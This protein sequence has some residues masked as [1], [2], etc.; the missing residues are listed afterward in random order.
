MPETDTIIPELTESLLMSDQGFGL[1][2]LEFLEGE[3]A[4]RAHHP[5]R[6]ALYPRLEDAFAGLFSAYPK[7]NDATF[8][9][10]FT[11]TQD[12]LQ[13]L[14]G[15]IDDQRLNLTLAYVEELYANF[16][17]PA[18]AHHILRD[19]YLGRG[20][21]AQSNLFAD[22]FASEAL[23]QLTG[24]NVDKDA[25]RADIVLHRLMARLFM[26]M[27]GEATQAQ[28]AKPFWGVL[29]NYLE[30]TETAD[31]AALEKELYDQFTHWKAEETV[32]QEAEQEEVDAGIDAL[33][34]DTGIG[35]SDTAT[36][37]VTSEPAT[38]LQEKITTDRRAFPPPLLSAMMVRAGAA[39]R[40]I[41]QQEIP[42]VAA[43]LQEELRRANADYITPFAT[44]VLEQLRVKGNEAGQWLQAG[45]A[46][47]SDAVREEAQAA[48]QQ[49]QDAGTLDRLKLEGKKALLTAALVAQLV[50]P[51]PRLQVPVAPLPAAPDGIERVASRA[52]E[53]KAPETPVLTPAPVTPSIPEPPAAQEPVSPLPPAAPP[54][55][56]LRPATPPPSQV[57]VSVD[58][59]S[60][61]T[62]GKATAERVLRPTLPAKKGY[63]N[64]TQ[65]AGVKAHIDAGKADEALKAL[66]RLTESFQPKRY[67]DGSFY[68]VGYGFYMGREGAKASWKKVFPGG[69]P[70]FNSVAKGHT[71][72]T[73]AQAEALLLADI[74]EFKRQARALLGKDAGGERYYDHLTVAQQVGITDLIYN[75]GAGRFKRSIVKPLRAA[76]QQ[77]QFD[78][79]IAHMRDNSYSG[80]KVGVHKRRL[81]EAVIFAQDPSLGFGE[82]AMRDY[83]N[84]TLARLP[85]KG[86]KQTRIVLEGGQAVDITMLK[87]PSRV[88]RL[89]LVQP[90]GKISVMERK[91]VQGRWQ[92]A[93][94]HGTLGERQYAELRK[95]HKLPQHDTMQNPASFEVAGRGDGG[96]GDSITR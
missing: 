90:D 80:S 25:P 66:V 9:A 45:M 1:R 79:F 87:I 29:E 62:L 15:P 47:V 42:A 22:K 21:A 65:Y 28:F 8:E 2:V 82:K 6:M 84:H 83:I 54:Q 35:R 17:S 51:R 92:V 46:H 71:K 12:I 58:A 77:G 32:A 52:P 59:S 11:R 85:K 34:A 7:M 95:R 10:I 40:K 55:A 48:W 96:A 41:G 70:N 74:K 30:V 18:A 94:S 24:N 37:T 91:K 26:Q 50:A 86:K 78:D 27:D 33:L 23:R 68:S 49:L 56:P 44:T 75:A 72:I 69:K 61:V 93:Y 76:I 67:R 16:K 63:C 81:I 43:A 88:A 4:E 19:I 5:D 89:E 60:V 73:K 57:P 14:Y 3:A 13:E 53:V 31:R 39:L 38:V 36:E 64:L 20:E